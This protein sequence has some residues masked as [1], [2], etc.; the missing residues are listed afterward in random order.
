MS[1]YYSYFWFIHKWE[2]NQIQ[3]V[4]LNYIWKEGALSIFQKQ[5]QNNLCCCLLVVMSL[6]MN[7]NVILRNP[8]L[9]LITFL[10]AKSLCRQFWLTHSPLLHL[11]FPM[12]RKSGRPGLISDWRANS[13]SP[14]GEPCWCP[15]H[16]MC[17]ILAHA[18][19][20]FPSGLCSMQQHFSQKSSPSECPDG[21][22]IKPSN[23]KQDIKHHLRDQT[24]AKQRQARFRQGKSHRGDSPGTAGGLT[25]SSCSLLQQSKTSLPFLSTPLQSMREHCHTTAGGQHWDTA[26]PHHALHPLLYCLSSCSSMGPHLGLFCLTMSREGNSLSKPGPSSIMLLLSPWRP[27]PPWPL[28]HPGTSVVAAWLS[29]GELGRDH[30]PTAFLQASSWPVL[31][32]EEPLPSPPSP[33][34]TKS[35]R[36]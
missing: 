13:S 10:I 15:S 30:H 5:N 2:A 16:F 4:P 34:A 28:L 24:K 27:A 35:D 3:K 33:A 6:L 14:A 12:Q 19:S 11:T 31:H 21:P 29:P 23:L 18:L 7:G 25:P 9:I 8:P 36:A 32:C 20:Y 1:L 22:Y 17:K 26:H